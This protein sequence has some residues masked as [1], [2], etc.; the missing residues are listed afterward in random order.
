MPD[1]G[2]ARRATKRPETLLDPIVQ[3]ILERWSS[4]RIADALDILVV[5]ILTYASISWLRRA[6]SRFVF[7]GLGGMV[8]LY[9]LARLLEMYLTLFI[10]QAVLTVAVVALVIIFQEDIR[11]GFERLAA[12]TR[13]GGAPKTL[14][15]SERTIDVVARVALRLA[16]QHLGALI[17]FKGREPLER[18]L[19]G[20]F[21]LEGRLS[22]TLLY[23]IFD[24]SS[25][26][27]DGAVVIDRSIVDRFGVHLPLSLSPDNPV[28]GTRHSAALGLSE[29]SDALVVVISEE[30]GAI[31]VAERGVLAEVNASGLRQRLTEFSKLFDDDATASR[32]GAQRRLGLKVLSVALAVAGWAVLT[33]YEAETVSRSFAVPVAYRN[34][35][36]HWLLED[37]EPDQVRVTLHGSIRAFQSI[38]PSTLTA[39]LDVRSVRE[40]AQPMTVDA[41]V[42]NVPGDLSIQHI[43][44][45]TVR[46][47]AYRAEEV[48]LPVRARTSGRMPAGLRLKAL[49]ADPPRVSVLVSRA[50]RPHHPSLSTEPVDLSSLRATTTVSRRVLLPPGVH[51]PDSRPVEVNV[52]AVVTEGGSAE[53]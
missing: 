42:L 45:R 46:V 12:G 27:H 16:A 35:Q 39:T 17:V 38:D 18:H 44:P 31:S 23:S 3:T 50:K 22:D 14:P 41:T 29:R 34:A 10:F 40:G 33:R 30:R 20:G 4:L 28:S 24:P 49:E 26:G 47:E 6:R 19:S 37:P 11:R 8:G 32:A 25:P 2:R 13:L 48:A 9:F 52:T 7:A 36:S 15:P 21:P 51:T 5:A 1:T 43:E 53:P